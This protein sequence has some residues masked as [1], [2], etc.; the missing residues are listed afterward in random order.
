MRSFERFLLS[1]LI[2]LLFGGNPASPVTAQGS[3]NFH[4]Y[5]SSVDSS[6]FPDI[7]LKARAVDENGNSLVGLEASQ[8]RIFEDDTQVN[9]DAVN[10][11]SPEKGPAAIIFLID[12]GMF[13]RSDLS[14]TR[15]KVLLTYYMNEYFRDGIDSVAIYARHDDGDN[16]DKNISILEPTHSLAEL[17]NA[18]ERLQM[19][20]SNVLSSVFSGVASVADAMTVFLGGQAGRAS[21]ALIVVSPYNETNL[22]DMVGLGTDIHDQNITGYVI[23]THESTV[24]MEPFQQFADLTGG[25]VIRVPSSEETT[26]K[27]TIVM[28][29]EIYARTQVI[30]VKYRSSYGQSGNRNVSMVNANETVQRNTDRLSY[31]VNLSDPQITLKSFPSEKITVGDPL[32]LIVELSPWNDTIQRQLVRAELFIDGKSVLSLPSADNQAVLSSPISFKIATDNLTPGTHTIE[33]TVTDELGLQGSIQPVNLTVPKVII[34]PTVTPTPIPTIDCGRSPFTAY[35][36]KANSYAIALGF[37]G[38]LVFLVIVVLLVFMLIR[39]TQKTKQKAGPGGVDEEMK[40]VVYGRKGQGAKNDKPLAK[41]HILIAG[42]GLEN[43]VIDIFSATTSF[44]RNPQK[45]DHQL[46]DVAA[47]STVSGLHCTITYD[48]GKFLLTDDNSQNGTFVRGKQITPNDPVEL[49]DG[50]EIV[51]GTPSMGGAKMR[52]EIVGASPFGG[53]RDADPDHTEIGMVPGMPGPDPNSA[54]ADSMEKTETFRDNPL[55][56]RPKKSAKADDD[57]MD[58]LQ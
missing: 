17:K 51:L 20:R 36:I 39:G 14:S 56:N 53:G 10:I 37:I 57:W 41:M 34:E 43:E 24:R 40:T 45:C 11:L 31:S 38:I 6:A 27:N 49:L 47:R 58:D 44:G 52:F 29:D 18:I 28:Y 26:P 5:I 35:C 50:D 21:T 16:N 13:S 32:N 4:F 7:S 9:P 15:L 46:Y 12:M 25:R 55:L 42:K 3:S 2:I 48:Y 1:L 23:F 54:P 8:I 30:N 33:V 22:P 19:V